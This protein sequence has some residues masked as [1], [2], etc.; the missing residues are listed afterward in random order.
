M[1]ERVNLIKIKYVDQRFGLECKLKMEDYRRV[2]GMRRE[3]IMAKIEGREP[4]EDLVIPLI[5]ISFP[6]AAYVM[7]L[8]K[9]LE[10]LG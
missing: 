4:E 5:R 1:P 2:V 3:K 8:D 10:N 7:Q 6:N 9:G